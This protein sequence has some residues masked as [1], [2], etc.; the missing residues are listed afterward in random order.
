MSVGQILID[1]DISGSISSCHR[2][3]TVKYVYTSRSTLV[4]VSVDGDKLDG[5]WPLCTDG[6]DITPPSVERSCSLMIEQGLAAGIR[7]FL[8]VSGYA[9]GKKAESF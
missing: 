8:G 3:I 9:A 5:R 6:N 4:I 7:V 2:N 1:V